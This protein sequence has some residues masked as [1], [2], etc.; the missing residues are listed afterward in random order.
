MHARSDWTP[1]RWVVI[2]A[3]YSGCWSQAW[4]IKYLGTT[5]K[6][7]R[8]TTSAAAG[9]GQGTTAEYLVNLNA[10]AVNNW[11]MGH[12]TQARRVFFLIPLVCSGFCSELRAPHRDATL[13]SCVC[14]ARACSRR[15]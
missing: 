12:Y 6:Y 10:G 7:L 14:G 15:L 2:G 11:A 3:G 5:I 9:N 8:R 13:G 4:A 1:P